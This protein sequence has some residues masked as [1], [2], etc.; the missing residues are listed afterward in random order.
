[1]KQD[2]STHLDKLEYI[3]IFAGYR[4]YIT[5]KLNKFNRIVNNTGYNNLKILKDEILAGRAA[6]IYSNKG[7]FYIMYLKNKKNIRTVAHEATH[8]SDYISR[9][10]RINDDEFRAHI[11]GYI[12]NC[13]INKGTYIR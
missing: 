8:I 5:N 6:I 11:V 10:L 4:L 9:D 3:E 13:I 7:P 2:I 12:T 1:M